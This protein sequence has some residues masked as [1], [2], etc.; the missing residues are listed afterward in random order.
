MP[1]CPVSCLAGLLA[2]SI[3]FPAPASACG[4]GLHIREAD[5][6]LELVS[7]AEPTWASRGE[8][9]LASSYLR[10]GS[11]A[12]DFQWI[13]PEIPFGHGRPLAY[14]LIDAAA[15]QADPRFSLFA[16]GHLSHQTADA[17]CE[18]FLVPHLFSSAAIGVQTA[19]GVDE[20]RAGAEA[21][22]E[23]P[24]DTAMGDWVPIVDVLFDFW[25][26]GPDAK[27]RG[28]EIVT[29]YCETGA[30][31]SGDAVD[32][33]L[34]WELTMDYLVMAEEYL[35]FMDRSQ[36]KQF[37]QLL[38]EQPM[39]DLLDMLNDE[40]LGELLGNFGIGG[41]PSFQTELDLLKQTPMME[42]EFW[43][44]YDALEDLG[45]SWATD[46]L[47][48]RALGWPGYSIHAMISGL[49]QSVLRFAPWADVVTG[50]VVDELTWL[51]SDGPVNSLDDALDGAE[52]VAR[53]SLYM[54][55]P[56]AGEIRG[57]VRADLPGLSAIEDPVVGEAT[58]EIDIEPTNYSHLPRAI[59]EVPFVTD[60]DGALGYT[61]DLMVDDRPA[62]AWT[63]SWD[64]LWG[65][66]GHDTGRRVYRTY[67]GTYGHWPPSLPIATPMVDSA[68]LLVTVRTG[69]DQGVG[70]AVVLGSRQGI[71]DP[72]GVLTFSD[73][74]AG[75][76]TVH[77]GAQGYLPSEATTQSLA[78]GE[79]RW[80]VLELIP[81]AE[82]EDCPAP[83]VPWGPEPEP[84]PVPE[85]GD[86][87]AEAPH[88]IEENP[89][90]VPDALVEDLWHPERE[91]DSRPQDVTP[92]VQD[93]TSAAS[94]GCVAA[95]APVTAPGI[96][97]VLILA[98]LFAVAL[99]RVGRKDP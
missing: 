43:D 46:L 73:V 86:S 95:A 38:V 1:R 82:D 30:A 9:E 57:V 81:C 63:T 4:P 65:L 87:W 44:Q 11:L 13:I 14:H 93:E 22:V 48:T 54:T 61:L 60:F 25:M 72:R 55:V 19:L 20:A 6:T 7:S 89:E 10:I 94:G 37:V 49:V 31:H 79:T 35:G 96:H 50:V 23:G 99:F 39:P 68:N 33:A 75:A 69:F 77:A 3:F 18:T 71:T 80:V 83:D 59:L 16:L 52:I 76:Y 5:R 62:P 88:A 64:A 85:S 2:L 21:I 45:P 70:G 91:N 58:L 36:A 67:Y 12:P 32:C 51:S 47:E 56:F 84:E 66:E 41:D 15:V 78:S 90:I 27:A 26:D 97:L 28:E 92:S 17:S 42:P 98:L 53:V 40:S 29:W 74:P 8:V 34:V 24:G